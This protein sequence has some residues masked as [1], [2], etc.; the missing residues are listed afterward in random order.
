V[1]W[2][3]ET[4]QWSTGDLQ[5]LHRERAL[6]E[7]EEFAALVAANVPDDLAGELI[8]AIDEAGDPEDDAEPGV[9]GDA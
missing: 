9:G 4:G 1:G 6:V 8:A 3:Q 2:H 5:W 7:A